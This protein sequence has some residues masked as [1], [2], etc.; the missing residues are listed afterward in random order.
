MWGLR[1]RES[2]L[3]VERLSDSEVVLLLEDLGHVEVAT[4]RVYVIH[5]K[6]LRRVVDLCVC[7]H[8]DNNVIRP[9]QYQ[10]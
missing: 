6:L 1:Q 8:H 4:R 2:D 7:Q 3:S 9:T 5:T 10:D